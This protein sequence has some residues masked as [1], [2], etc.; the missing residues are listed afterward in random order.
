MYN[1]F[2]FD[3]LNQIPTL[4]KTNEIRCEHRF[5]CASIPEGLSNS[6]TE[7]WQYLTAW[8]IRR[9]IFTKSSRQ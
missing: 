8:K 5:F 6:S 9:V 1:W 2:D 4:Y 3:F 7:F